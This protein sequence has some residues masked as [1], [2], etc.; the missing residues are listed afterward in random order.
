MKS[1]QKAARKWDAKQFFFEVGSAFRQ[2]TGLQPGFA[3]GFALGFGPANLASAGSK[4]SAKPVLA[5]CFSPD[6]GGSI[7][8]SKPPCSSCHNNVRVRLC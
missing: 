5:R 4:P 2:R 1:C 3:L 6:W 7:G 8:V